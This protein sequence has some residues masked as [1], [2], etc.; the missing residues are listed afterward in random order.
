MD[1]SNL[2]SQ[3][4]PPEATPQAAHSTEPVEM[5]VFSDGPQRRPGPTS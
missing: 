2:F 4:D 1:T 5:P 3:L